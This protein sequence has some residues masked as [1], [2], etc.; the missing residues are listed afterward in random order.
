MISDTFFVTSLKTSL[1]VWDS[2]ENHPDDAENLHMTSD[3]KQRVSAFLANKGQ[4]GGRLPAFVFF[5]ERQ[6][7]V[8]DSW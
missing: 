7:V 6:V 8:V 5:E 4:V 3:V 2:V 1:R